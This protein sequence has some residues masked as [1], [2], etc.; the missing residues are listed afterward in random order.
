MLK[1]PIKIKKMDRYRKQEYKYAGVMEPEDMTD[2]K[3]VGRNTV[4]VQIPSPAP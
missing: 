2:L 3:S 4:R 1:W